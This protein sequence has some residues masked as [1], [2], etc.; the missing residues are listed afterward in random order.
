[1]NAT[2]TNAPTQA[3]LIELETRAAN[4]EY[5]TPAAL[6]DAR[7]EAALEAFGRAAALS[8]QV[9]SRARAADCLLSPVIQGPRRCISK[10]LENAG[11]YRS[12]SG[13]VYRRAAPPISG[14]ARS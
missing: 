5:I 12:S 8:T 10:P 6:W 13:R 4:G 7:E 14:R 11:F 2:Q 1:M 3:E 9:D